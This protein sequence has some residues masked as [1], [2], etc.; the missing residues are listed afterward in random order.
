MDEGLSEQ[1]ERDQL[2]QSESARGSDSTGKRKRIGESTDKKRKKIK[3][4]KD[5]GSSRNVDFPNGKGSQQPLRNK[6][7]A[8]DSP[9]GSR[10][11]DEDEAEEDEESEDDRKGP[12]G[13]DSYSAEIFGGAEADE[14]VEDSESVGPDE[15]GNASRGDG[16]RK[17]AVDDTIVERVRDAQY[18]VCLDP[19]VQITHLTHT[20]VTGQSLQTRRQ[21]LGRD[22]QLPHL[23][24]QSFH[25]PLFIGRPA[26]KASYHGR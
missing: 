9:S 2:E 14:T 5:E 15:D 6:P 7:T 22:K 11:E 20:C 13:P 12:A 19:I 18:V 26:K 25:L 1:D 23:K 3:T 4:A 16:D 10:R 8:R 24:K 21:R 17:E